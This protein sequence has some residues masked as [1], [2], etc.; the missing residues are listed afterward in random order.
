M[1]ECVMS[2]ECLMTN[3]QASH[4]ARDISHWDLFIP[5]SL[6]HYSLNHSHKYQSRL[7]LLRS[8]GDGCRLQLRAHY[9]IAQ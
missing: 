4:V 5:D 7:P 6:T 2:G 9:A 8:K 3:D 1:S